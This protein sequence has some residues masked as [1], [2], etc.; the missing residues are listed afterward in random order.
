MNSVYF[1]TY[2]LDG[3]D[4]K[5]VWMW[6]TPE[7]RDRFDCS[8]LAQ[9]EIVFSHMTARGLMLHVITQET[10]ND[11]ALGG[12]PGLNPERMLYY[13]E[14][15]ARFAHQPAIVWNLGEENNTPDEDRKA[16]A[17]YI[18]AVDPYDHPIAV[19]SHAN[20]AREDYAGILG[21]DPTSRRP[22]SR[23][24]WTLTTVM[25]STSGGLRRRRD[26]PG[27]SSATSRIRPPAASSPTATT[28]T[29]TPLASRRYGA[30]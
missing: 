6:T 22:R 21:V 4:G 18:R 25:R 17:G 15:I 13:R 5:D 14:L 28:R 10:E 16:I 1:L 27:P 2:N 11:R 9:W 26:A 23:A 7:V 8:K 20:R 19:H 30:T 24:P 12:G 29:T 3:G